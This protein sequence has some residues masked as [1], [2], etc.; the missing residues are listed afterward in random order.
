M[1]GQLL[2]PQSTV[3]STFSRKVNCCRI[4]DR[5]RSRL[6]TLTEIFEDFEAILYEFF[7]FPTEIQMKN[8]QQNP[9]KIDC[10]LVATVAI[11]FLKPRLST[12]G[13]LLKPQLTVW[14]TFSRKVDCQSKA[15]LK[16][17]FNAWPTLCLNWPRCRG[18][19]STYRT[20]RCASQCQDA[21]VQ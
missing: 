3:W 9:R 10:R 2:K 21:A 7:H 4:S 5:P 16:G 12:V 8:P 13:Q 17:N 6:L 15:I 20:L 18:A 11:F 1:Y 14:S 19:V